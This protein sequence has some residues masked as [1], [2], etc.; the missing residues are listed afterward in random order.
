MQRTVKILTC[1]YIV[2]GEGK[3]VNVAEVMAN[4]ETEATA[5][6]SKRHGKKGCAVILETTARTALYELDDEIF[7]KYA[8]LVEDKDA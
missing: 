7:F 5:I 2:K 8:T 1:E 4:N 3:A 6:L